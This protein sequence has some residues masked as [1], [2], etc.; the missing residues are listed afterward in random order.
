MRHRRRTA[1]SR[2]G[3]LALVVGVVLAVGGPLLWSWTAASPTPPNLGAGTAVSLA[4]SP[5]GDTP[6]RSSGRAAAAPSAAAPVSSAAPSPALVTSYARSSVS[7][8]PAHTS[9]RSP[10]PSAAGPVAPK[11]SAPAGSAPTRLRIEALALDAPVIPV[12]VDERGELAI[13]A[14]VDTVGW[15]RYGSA[16]GSAT[17]SVVLAGHVDSAQQGV[18]AFRALWSAEPGTMI[19]LDRNNG[20]PLTY[21][22][23]SRETFGKNAI[24]LTALFATTGAPR[25]TLITCGGPFDSESLSYTD[26]VVVTAVPT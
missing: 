13:P 25:L 4:R 16:A 9:H 15:Y 17:G 7:A 20:G 5:A 24:P 14:D 26:N 10:A 22:V 18:G 6:A 3:L 11:G 19:H 23:V 1:N 8:V 12:G 21:R 2:W